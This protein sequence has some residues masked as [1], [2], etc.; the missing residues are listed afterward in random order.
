VSAAAVCD[1]VAKGLRRPD[2]P[3]DP[4]AAL[5]RLVL[6]TMHFTSAPPPTRAG[7][8]SLVLSG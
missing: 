2:W 5:R 7:R 3:E 8:P 1:G 6:M 4:W